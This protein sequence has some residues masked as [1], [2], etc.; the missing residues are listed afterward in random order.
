MDW[1][2]ERRKHPRIQI[3]PVL[4]F[5]LMGSIHWPVWK[6]LLLLFLVVTAFLLLK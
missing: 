2:I 3:A 5:L 1:M 6:L 4:R